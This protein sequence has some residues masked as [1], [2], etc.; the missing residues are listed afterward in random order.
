MTVS[1][2]ARWTLG[3]K[4]GLL[5]T[6]VML[7]AA[8]CG[9]SGDGDGLALERFAQIEVTPPDR[10]VV[11]V[12][13][14]LPAGETTDYT[15]FLRNTGQRDLE[16]RSVEL[17]YTPP[18]D[19][20]EPEP[21]FNLVLPASLEEGRGPAV[22]GPLDDPGS[23]PPELP[24]TVVFTHRDEVPR[25]AELVIESNSKND[26]RLVVSLRTEEG[27]PVA[28]LSPDEVLFGEV[29]AGESP[30][31]SVTLLNTGAADLIWSGFR[32]SGDSDFT[33]VA[34]DGAGEWPVSATT[35]GGVELPAPV[36]VSPNASAVFGVR[37]APSGDR[38]QEAQLVLLTND[39]EQSGGIPVR[40]AGNQRLARIEVVPESVDFR[41]VIVGSLGAVFVRVR[42]VG[43]GE[44]AITGLSLA[45]GSSL[46]FA[47]DL[48]DVPLLPDG[49][50]PTPEAPVVVPANETLS[51]LVTYAP[52][53]VAARDGDDQPIPDEGT[54]VIANNSFEAEVEVPL[55]G[56]GVLSV[57]PE[58]V[59]G[60]LEGDEVRPQTVV[61]LV[62]DESSS[63]CGAIE[64]WEWTVSQPDGSV[65]N[66][67]P[68]ASFPDPSFACNVAGSYEF[69][70]HVWDTCGRRSCEQSCVEVVAIPDEAIHVELLWTTPEDPDPSDEGLGLGADLDLHFTHP[71]A[72]LG[73]EDL[74]GDGVS[75][76]WF[77]QLYDCFW[78]NPA[79]FWGSLD[80]TVDD[81]PGLDRD[82]TDGG[83]PE[84]VNL[85]RPEDLA[86]LPP[87][88]LDAIGGG[89]A[90]Y[91]IGVHYWDD[92]GFG[93][94]YATV[95]V[96]VFGELVLERADVPLRDLDMWD[97]AT[98]EWPSA[99]VVEV[100]DEA[101]GPR[102]TPDYEHPAFI[103]PL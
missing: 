86:A 49:V 101:G 2:I 69:C 15:L 85:N 84:N 39:P 10:D 7:G 81:D 55:R 33:F 34:P 82:D 13:G 87:E 71:F 29:Q 22:V 63:D 102:I 90:A 52:D 60:V 51:F 44:L 17:R 56:V 91:R 65:S 66:L 99:V 79:P 11:L 93:L 47:L 48:N 54:L 24:V 61:H 88:L 43:T 64:R 57:C 27:R 77:D 21:P 3:G 70:L 100:S 5:W 92:H 58:A 38:A 30:E 40:L 94:S 8:A 97:V 28:V 62:S 6:F 73:G 46:D 83:G 42:S 37:F 67:V 16:I 98:I 53:Q 76:R 9:A 12:V 23:A 50:A 75:D 25:A 18:G 31:I 26:D 74:D 14:S 72:V 96:Y 95:R 89:P 103:N 59:A 45:E 80:P 36:V 35:Q 41:E 32:L 78:Y 1:H 4:L 19:T 20:V 68:T